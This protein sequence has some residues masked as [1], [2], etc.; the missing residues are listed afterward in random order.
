MNE[1]QKDKGLKKAMME[2][3]KP[4]LPS[5]FTFRT[6]QRIEE[7]AL[8][9]EKRTDRLMLV[10]TVAASVFLMV[11]GA[12]CLFLYCGDSIRSYAL[13]I[14]KQDFRNLPGLP[15]YILFITAFLLCLWF[16]N[17]MRKWYFR[18]HS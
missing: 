7:A 5:N 15:L 10:A 8:L 13:T 14:S 17:R 18:R 3:P 12:L 4:C 16:D 2:Q 11:C 6:M 1:G 9:R